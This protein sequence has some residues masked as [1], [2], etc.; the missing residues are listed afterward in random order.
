[1]HV[2]VI[3][4]VCLCLWKCACVLHV[5][6]LCAPV[7]AH[8]GRVCRYS[9]VL[10]WVSYHC[11]HS[12]SSHSQPPHTHTHTHT[13][14]GPQL[15][16]SQSADDLLFKVLM[17][18]FLQTPQ[19]LASRAL[20]RSHRRSGCCYETNG[21]LSGEQSMLPF[22]FLSYLKIVECHKIKPL[23]PDRK[24]STAD[25]GCCYWNSANICCCSYLQLNQLPQLIS[26][27]FFHHHFYIFTF[28]IHIFLEIW[29]TSISVLV[30]RP[31]KLWG[32]TRPW[33]DHCV[34]MFM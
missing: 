10:F 13:H 14:A 19:H 5:Q 7:H 17:S 18:C 34:T 23:H 27:L 26:G 22:P 29:L 6:C 21:N 20:Q 12:A 9:T 32:L 30:H 1:M 28:Q 2:F 33:T 11:G 4:C 31:V 8:V 3:T 15:S 16:C 24:S 25:V